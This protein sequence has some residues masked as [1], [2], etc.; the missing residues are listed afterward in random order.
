MDFFISML[1]YSYANLMHDSS[2]HF[3][4]TFIAYQLKTTVI[5]DR[6]DKNRY[7]LV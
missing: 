3:L 1:T 4:E 2:D 5:A 6:L 7:R